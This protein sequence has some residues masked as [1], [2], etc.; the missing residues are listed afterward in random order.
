MNNKTFH[1]LK[2]RATQR[3][4]TK[5]L[6]S[7]GIDASSQGTKQPEG[8]RTTVKGVSVTKPVKSAC[9]S[10]TGL[11]VSVLTLVSKGV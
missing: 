2:T 4:L 5:M 10:Y 3:K 8:W 6:K 11:P 9:V 7:R 1:F